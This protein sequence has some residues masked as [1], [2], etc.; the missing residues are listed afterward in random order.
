MK[1][2]AVAVMA[3]I[4]LAGCNGGAIKIGRLD[5]IDYTSEAE[6]KKD[7][8]VGARQ[9]AYIG[10]SLAR[11]HNY[12]GKKYTRALVATK[13]F[14]LTG[15]FTTR[16]TYQSDLIFNVRQGAKLPVMG[17]YTYK[18]TQ[19]Y[20]AATRD[21]RDNTH[22]LLIDDNGVLCNN[23]V[24]NDDNDRLYVAENGATTPV[25]VL[26]SKQIYFDRESGSSGLSHELIFGGIND[27]TLNLSYREY[28]SDLLARPAFSQNLIYKTGADIIRFKNI[29]IQIYEVTNEKITYAVISDEL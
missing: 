12:Y 14:T 27:V 22:G 26:F 18:G 20:V 15:K 4:M 6:L 16:G 7:Y 2:L 25:D 8:T 17:Q 11:W 13:A 5:K 21:S 24:T 1:R 23:A 3:L 28:T 19:Y 10:D 9:T 29:K